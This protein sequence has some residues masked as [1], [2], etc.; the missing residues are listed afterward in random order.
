MV[1][2]RHFVST[3]VILLAGLLISLPAFS[4]EL[5]GV[6]HKIYQFSDSNVP[7]MDGDL[8]DWDHVPAEYFFDYRH[9]GQAF[10]E[11]GDQHNKADLHIKRVG[12]GWNDRLNRLYFMVEIYDN[13]HLFQKTP[14]DIEKLVSYQGG[15]PGDYDF[16]HGSDIFEV[17]IDAD[18]GGEQVMPLDK[19]EAEER[20]FRSAY[21]Q[22]Y[23]LY[24]PPVNGSMWLWMWGA[25]KWPDD[26]N[27]SDVGW[28]YEGLHG[29]SGTVTYE[30]YLTPFDDLHPDGP[31]LSKLH[32]LTEGAIIGLSWAFLDADTNSHAQVRFWSLTGSN[33]M[34]IRG[35]ALVDFK[36]MPK[37][38]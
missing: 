8:T 7:E 35:D 31:E 37:I 11:R 34:A 36:L 32:D 19:D 16:V 30:C 17:V 5:D 38:P 13:V 20:R 3:F 24:I 22:N 12:A 27:Y 26:P 2:T 23:H 6:I 18:H 10:K 28:R 25:A 15:R 14:E 4:H 21:T 33:E 1:K 29:S 9:H